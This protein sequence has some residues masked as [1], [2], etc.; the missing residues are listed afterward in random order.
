MKKRLNLFL[1]SFL[2]AASGLLVTQVL[3]A[4]P[5][6]GGPA[7]DT[8]V[9]G[10]QGLRK[11][12]S[13][14]LPAR[15]DSSSA[16]GVPEDAAAT[17]GDFF[18]LG[19]GGNLVLGFTNPIYNGA[20]NDLYVTETTYG[21]PPGYPESAMVEVSAD[22]TTWVSAGTLTQDGAVSMPESVACAY[23]VR[24][25]DTTDSK[26][27]TQTEPVSKLPTNSRSLCQHDV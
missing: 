15:S 16:L 18:S 23:Y 10:A 17:E 24:I 26:C 20:G 4:P 1:A 8:V 27:V 2:V 14:V 21:N 13:A 19:F 3:A 25:T 7:A 11:D 22:G 12:G 6:G 5:N 9:S